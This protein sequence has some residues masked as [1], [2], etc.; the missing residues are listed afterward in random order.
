M[1]SESTYYVEGRCALITALTKSNDS[2]SESNY[3]LS[4]KLS[5]FLK[6]FKFKLAI[7]DILAIISSS[8]D[9]L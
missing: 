3:H 8:V 6:N 5:I 2:L 9:T 1:V 4:E 7:A